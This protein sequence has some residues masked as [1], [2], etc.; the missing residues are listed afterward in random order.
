[1]QQLVS[2]EDV[3]QIMDE[4]QEAVDYQRQISDLLSGGLTDD[5]ESE[6]RSR[7]LVVSPP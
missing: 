4:T 5:D 2:I 6:V 3:E 7:T 1:M